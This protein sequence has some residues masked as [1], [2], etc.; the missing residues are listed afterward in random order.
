M[1]RSASSWSC[2]ERASSSDSAFARWT[3]SRRRSLLGRAQ[4]ADPFQAETDPQ[5]SA[6]PR[7]RDGEHE[8]GDRRRHPQYERW[9]NQR[10]GEQRD[11]SEQRVRAVPAGDAVER[12]RSVVAA[13]RIPAGVA[14][15]KNLRHRARLDQHHDRRNR[16]GHH[17]LE[18][19][20]DNKRKRSAGASAGRA[21]EQRE[22]QAEKLGRE[23]D[24]HRQ[25]EQL[26][27][28]FVVEP[29]PRRKERELG[30]EILGSDV[31]GLQH[32]HDADEQLH[33]PERR[34]EIAHDAVAK[35]WRGRPGE[36][37]ARR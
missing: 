37:L 10:R 19:C 14:P 30:R 20:R 22:N 32:Q 25:L 27:R 1:A 15:R 24:R 3:T 12:D 23:Q 11:Q 21:V 4:E 35:C 5:L 17:D 18:E 7:K 16:G 36:A 33:H 29:R 6:R 8:A 26:Q 34:G 2:P 9:R 28:A 13:L 31:V